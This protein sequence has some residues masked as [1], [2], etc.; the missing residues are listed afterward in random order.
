MKTLNVAETPPVGTAAI[1]GAVLD[2]VLTTF[3]YNS[4]SQF[5]EYFGSGP[6]PR[7]YGGSCAWQSFE[8]GRLVAE[9]AG[10]EAEYWID[11]RHVAAVYRDAGGMTLLDPY[12]L[13][14]PPLRLERADAVDGEVRLAVDAY[15]FRIREDG[16]AAPSR[17]RVCWVP[18]DDSVRLDHLRFSPRR[19]H[20]VI[21]RSFT[22]RRERQLTEVP[23]P[24]EW[25]RP[26][27][28]HPEQHSVSVRVVHPATRELAEIILP[29]A[30]RPTGVVSDT[31]SMITKNNQGAVA[32]HGARAFH[33]D[34]EVVADAVGSPRQDVVDFLLEAAALHLAA[35]P[36]GLETAAYSLEDE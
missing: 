15:P 35:A 7:G 29:L 9:R 6:A 34:S 13:H 19:G 27:L 17:V 12:L 1:H 8:A 24:A 5:H 23:P 18:E 32:R 11:G 2:E 30:G 20:N 22:L 14:C 21:S 28:L 10:A 16:S 33:R 25:V 36:A 4:A 26:Q 31:E 3:P